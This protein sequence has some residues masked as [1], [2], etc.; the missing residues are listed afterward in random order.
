MVFSLSIL[1]LI[2][3]FERILYLVLVSYLLVGFER[4]STCWSG[5]EKNYVLVNMF[6]V[7]F[8]NVL[9]Q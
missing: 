1:G 2:V 9:L 4:V 5:S 8:K 6:F 3:I 7:P